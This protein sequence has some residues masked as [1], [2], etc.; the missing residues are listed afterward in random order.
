M[1]REILVVVFLFI[2]FGINIVSSA[3]ES[4]ICSDIYYSVIKVGYDYDKISQLNYSKED[5]DNFY[6]NHYELCVETNLTKPFPQ[7][8]YK[9]FLVNE[10]ECE[11]EDFFFDYT[12]PF[13][14]LNV[15]EL[16]CD[17]VKLFNYFFT[18]EERNSYSITNLRIWWILSI[19]L[20]VIIFS[21]IRQDSWLKIIIRKSLKRRETFKNDV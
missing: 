14:D 10:T 21:S 1:K 16:S 15:G 6:F 3:N 2:L 19:F 13:F 9:E 18:L 7:R 12:F 20:I 17:N 11:I 5:I 4:E 8:Q